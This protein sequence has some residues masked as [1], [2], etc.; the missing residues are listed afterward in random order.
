MAD[1][2]TDTF[3]NPDTHEAVE[4]NTWDLLVKGA[5]R[6]KEAFHLPVIGTNANFGPNLRTIVLRDIIRKE[7]K[8]I[9]HTDIRSAKIQELKKD[10]RISFLFY[11]KSKRLQYRIGTTATIHTNDE[12]ADQQWGNSNLSSRRCYLAESPTIIKDKPSHGLPD[13]LYGS[14]PEA[15]ES[16]AGRINFVVVSC[17]VNF[18]DWLWLHHKGH[19]RAQFRYD[20]KLNWT[21]NWV[22]P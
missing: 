8:L 12:L 14:L 7:K 19:R 2:N 3:F 1:P 16:E 21:A 13:H 4:I 18:I 20:E 10:N 15:E 17:R 22:T 9:F 11:D 5:H 6:S